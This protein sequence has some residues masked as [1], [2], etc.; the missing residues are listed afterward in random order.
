MRWKKKKK[1]PHTIT[2][3][4]HNICGNRVEHL[5]PKG[6]PKVVSKDKQ[7]K[8][9]VIANFLVNIFARD[10]GRR[11]LRNDITRDGVRYSVAL[12]RLND[13]RTRS[14]FD[15]QLNRDLPKRGTAI[16]T[17]LTLFSKCPSRNVRTLCDFSSTFKST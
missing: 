6:L 8:A 11:L 1:R 10:S 13:V 16:K 15:S 14:V 5:P 9:N 17:L 3:K 4:I 7:Y 2:T 12:R